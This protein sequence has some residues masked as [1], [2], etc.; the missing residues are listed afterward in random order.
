MPCRVLFLG[1]I[2]GSYRIQPDLDAVV[3]YVAVMILGLVVVLV[4]ATNPRL[5][6]DQSLKFFEGLVVV[7]LVGV[8]LAAFG[9]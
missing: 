6:I 5:R 9:Y 2:T 7:A 3:N 4:D 1:V 8:G